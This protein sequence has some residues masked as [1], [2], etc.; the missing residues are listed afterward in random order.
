MGGVVINSEPIRILGASAAT[1]A[2]V[3]GTV[4][5]TALATI[6]VPAGAMGLN[7]IIRVTP[8]FSYTNSANNKTLRVRL[9]GIGGPAFLSNAATT[10]LLAQPIVLIRNRGVA[11]SQVGF[12][13]AT[14]S[15]VGITTGALATGSVDTSAATT[16][17]ISGQLANTGETIT[18]ESY[19]VELIVP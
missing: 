13:A 12:T 9:G 5:E 2:S 6:T 17:V 11:N 19:L 8:L 18:L 3:T 10:T 16:V 7:G 15:S 14:F 4:T 1:G